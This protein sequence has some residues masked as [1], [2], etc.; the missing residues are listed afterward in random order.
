MT[1]YGLTIKQ[2]NHIEQ[3][4]ERHFV[5]VNNSTPNIAR[6]GMLG[7]G[8]GHWGMGEDDMYMYLSKFDCC[9][10]GTLAHKPTKPTK[11]GCTCVYNMFFLCA[12]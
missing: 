12:P 9:T 1:Q 4:Q 2:K 8:E 11:L 10:R 5:R 7:G 6:G 3:I